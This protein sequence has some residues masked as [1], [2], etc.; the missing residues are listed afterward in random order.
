[1]LRGVRVA[2]VARLAPDGG[3]MS[4]PREGR[5]CAVCGSTEIEKGRRRYCSERCLAVATAASTRARD[6]KR[7]SGC[8]RCGGAKEP[9]V[10]GGKYCAACRKIVADSTAQFER[11]RHRRRKAREIQERIDRGEVVELRQPTYRDGDK[12]CSRCKEYLPLTSFPTRKGD[13]HGHYCRPCQRSYNS[14]RR[15]K[16][17]FG[18]TWDEYELIYATQDGRCAICGGRPRKHMLSIDHDHKTGEIRGLLCSRCNH[19]LLGSANDDPARLRRAADYLEEYAVREV[20]GERRFV[21][22]MGGAS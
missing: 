4:A 9:G 20:F 16:L 19:R 17:Q 6:D 3:D 10:R 18:L 7:I 8:K 14:E 11:E 21:P 5:T 15:M 22:G 1:M 13:K 2:V 12:W